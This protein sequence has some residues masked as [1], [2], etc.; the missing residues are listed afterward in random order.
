MA[1]SRSSLS[2]I[3]AV[4][5]VLAAAVVLPQ[6]LSSGDRLVV[7]CAHDAALAR[8]VIAGVGPGGH[9]LQEDHTYDNFRRELWQPT[10][11]T[12]QS[13]DDWNLAGATSMAQRVQGKTIELIEGHEADPLPNKTLAALEQLKQAGEAE[14]AQLANQ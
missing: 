5:A 1:G 11:L 6:F 3:L 12:R 9:F 4:A 7:Y 10:L 8:D 13:R 2:L 14:L